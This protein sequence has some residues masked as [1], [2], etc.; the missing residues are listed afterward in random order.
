[1]LD[2]DFHDVFIYYLY[3]YF[4]SLYENFKNTIYPLF[5][6]VTYKKRLLLKHDS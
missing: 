1:M 2:L 5:N 6:Y 4:F 3:F